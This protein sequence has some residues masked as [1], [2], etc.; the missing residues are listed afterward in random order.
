MAASQR[1]STDWTDQEAWQLTMHG[2]EMRMMTAYFLHGYSADVNSSHVPLHQRITVFRSR[3]IN[4]KRVAARP[5]AVKAMMA[6][7]NYLKSGQTRFDP[8]F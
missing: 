6:L 7:A 2:T 8:I 5:Q 1:A 3:P 4:L